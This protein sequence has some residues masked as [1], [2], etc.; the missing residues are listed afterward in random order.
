M[1]ILF[2][3]RLYYPH[4]GGV[5]R[6]VEEVGKRLVKKGYKVTIV[7]ELLGETKR[8]ETIDGIKIIRFTYPKI[9]FLGLIF[10]WLQLLRRFQLI[11]TSDIVHIH[12]VFVWY[13]PFRF[14]FPK[15]VVYTT[16]HG[17]E[18]KYPIPQ[19]F[20]FLRKV[21]ERLS[22]GN[23][24][25]GDYLKK[26]YGTNSDFVTYGGVNK[27]Q[28]SKFKIKNYNSRFKILFVGRLAEDPGLPM[29]L[30][31]FKFLHG[32]FEIMFLGDGKLRDKA[33]EFGKVHGFV[34]D[35]IPYLIKAKFVFTSGYL[36]ILEAMAAKKL[37]FAVY[38]NPV[39]RDYLKMAPFAKWIVAENSPKILAEKI[40]YY[41]KHPEEEKKLVGEGYNWVQ[42][43]T[44]DK[45]VSLYLKLWGTK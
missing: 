35:I 32:R 28:N 22:L 29:Y 25:A 45:V 2:L 44:W 33:Q 18:G 43:Q 23:I 10:I 37:V 40:K 36:S 12:D 24:C 16:F 13:L 11:K 41:L 3:T 19:K 27:V 6:H 9:K 17:W 38:D 14:L 7:T 4:I 15:K 1:N 21:A 20:K 5:E 26:W 39:K 31:A 8:E 30:D 34:E 42:Q